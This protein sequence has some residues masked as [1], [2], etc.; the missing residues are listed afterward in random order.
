M[1][2]N[3]HW[4]KDFFYPFPKKRKIFKN[5]IAFL[6]KREIIELT[7]LRQVGKS[8]LIFQL[9]NHLIN[10]SQDRFHILYFTF[11]EEVLKIDELFENYFK[12]TGIDYKKEKI[13]CF[14]D[15]IQKLPNFQN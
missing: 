10:L 4:E 9:I 2:Y 12:Q 11:D 15:E 7:G 5:L 14:L 6:D 3:R 13:Y 1:K 8:T